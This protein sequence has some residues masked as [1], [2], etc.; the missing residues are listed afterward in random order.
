MLST[1]TSRCGQ[2]VMVRRTRIIRVEVQIANPIRRGARMVRSRGRGGGSVVV[3]GLVH[4]HVA[5]NP[6]K[7]VA[8]GEEVQVQV[9]QYVNVAGP[10]R[11]V[12]GLVRLQPPR[13]DHVLQLR[14]VAL[15]VPVE[16]GLEGVVAGYD[17]VLDD[18]LLRP[19]DD[20]AIL[21]VRGRSE[22]ARYASRP[23]PLAKVLD[24]VAGRP[25]GAGWGV[26]NPPGGDFLAGSCRGLP[27]GGIPKILTEK[28]RRRALTR[29]L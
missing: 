7:I 6:A 17:E 22:A 19:V 8:D 29:G 14:L 5:D 2:V 10:L 18:A 24:L 3:R 13:L 4:V 26:R 9:A 12:A 15:L 16:G 27:V 23:H 11:P 21:Q 28:A 1:V 20:A 25:Q